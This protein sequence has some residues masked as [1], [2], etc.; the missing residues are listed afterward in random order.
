MNL[1]YIGIDLGT[2]AM[3]LLL[4]DETGSILNAV[5]REYPLHFP[6]QG[7]SEQDP[8]DWWNACILGI[9]E[10]LSGFDKGRVAGIGVAGQMHGLVAL[11]E[12]DEIIRPAILWNDGRTAEETEWLNT[13]IGKEKLSAY[14]GNIAFAGFTAP[15]LLWMQKHEPEHFAQIARIMLPKDYLNYRL[16]GV[17]ACDYSD[18]SGML[19]LDVRHKRWSKEMLDICHVSESQMP[20]LFESY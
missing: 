12:Q 7:W 13:V 11:D 4:T 14:T 9:P 3:K 8:A 1:Y 5:T 20:K 17:H 16:T 15:K 19:L 2:S 18:G 6:Q 10:L